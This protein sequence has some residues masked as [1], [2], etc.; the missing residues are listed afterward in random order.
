MQENS[1]DLQEKIK[2]LFEYRKLPYLLNL[3]EPS[4]AKVDALLLRLTN[5]QV[6]IYELDHYLESNWLIEG[7][8]LDQ[9]W[10]KMYHQLEVCGVKKEMH[11]DFL[12]HVKKYQEHELQLREGKLPDRLSMEYFYFYKSCDVKLLRR[13]IYKEYPQLES[14]F[15]LAFWKAFDLSTEVDDDIED[16]FEDQYTINANRFLIDSVLKGVDYTYSY[17]RSFLES[18]EHTYFDGFDSKSQSHMQLK[19]WSLKENNK[20]ID[21]LIQLRHDL[22]KAKQ[23]RLFFAN[24]LFQNNNSQT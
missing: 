5:L 24:K 16:V 18:I 21:R 6:S 8:Y 3:V 2:A 13:I 4:S 17:F 15:P 7:K 22:R 9:Y 20:T 23:L 12:A 19:E 1:S 14:L 11:Q 10:D